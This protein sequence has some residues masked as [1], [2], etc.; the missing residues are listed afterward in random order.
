MNMK[1]VILLDDTNPYSSASDT[2]IILKPI[3]E[4]LLLVSSKTPTMYLLVM[5]HLQLAKKKLYLES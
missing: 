5:L 1:K 3:L 4:C 2:Q